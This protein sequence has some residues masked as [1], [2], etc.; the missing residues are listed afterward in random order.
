[1]NYTHSDLIRHIELET[2][3]DT[4]EIKDILNEMDRYT[5]LKISEATKDNPVTIKISKWFT[6]KATV[7]KR[8]ISVP[9]F[10]KGGVAK[11]YE[12]IRIAIRGIVSEDFATQINILCG[13]KK[14]ATPKMRRR[15]GFD[16]LDGDEDEEQEQTED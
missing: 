11:K 2:G 6:I 12:A 8:I 10:K 16:P 3:Y 4:Q 9:D 5:Q 15:M 13:F 1:M 14:D 7:R